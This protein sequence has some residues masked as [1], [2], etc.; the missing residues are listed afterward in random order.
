MCMCLYKIYLPV[1][2]CPIKTRFFSQKPRY[3]RP[4][5]PKGWVLHLA[6]YSL[7]QKRGGGGGGIRLLAWFL[8]AH[9]SPK[10]PAKLQLASSFNPARYLFK[11][12]LAVE[13]WRLSRADVCQAPLMKKLPFW[14]GWGYSPL[15]KP[16]LYCHTEPSWTDVTFVAPKCENLQHTNQQLW[17]GSCFQG[18]K[19]FF[20]I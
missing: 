1:V 9:D 5:S 2:S 8:G 19:R 6:F 7:A 13:D 16:N 3:G 4:G 11:S 10:F 14:G 15:P 17:W 12:Q 20:F 18:N